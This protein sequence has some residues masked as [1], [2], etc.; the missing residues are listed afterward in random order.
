MGPEP[1]EG[2][3]EYKLMIDG[4][5]AHRMAQLATQMRWRIEEGGGEAVYSIGVED[6]GRCVGLAPDALA[7]S[8]EAVMALAKV[9]DAVVF[10]VIK[11]KGLM[12]DIA[13][14]F[15]RRVISG[16]F[17]DVRVT[18]IGNVDAGKST[19]VGVLTRGGLDNGRG[20]ARSHVFRHAHEIESGRTS[21]ISQQIVGVDATGELVTAS[22]TDAKGHISDLS[23]EQI[24]RKSSKVINFIDLCGHERYFKTTMTG[25]TSYMPDYSLV[26][27]GANAGILRMTKEHVSVAL[28]LKCPL[29]FAVT[30]IDIAPEQILNDSLKGIKKILKSNMAKK[31]GV[32]V[33]SEED[34]LM[35]IKSVRTDKRLVPI[36]QVSAVTGE[37]LQLLRLY[38]SLLPPKA[39]ARAD[40]DMPCELHIDEVFPQVTGIGCVVSGTVRRGRFKDELFKSQQFVL[41]PD[42][43]GKWNRI[44]VK[45]MMKKRS[46][47][48]SIEAGQSGTMAIKGQKKDIK[49]IVPRRGMVL[50]DAKLNPRAC[51]TFEASVLI[52]HHPTTIEVGYSPMVHVLTVRQTV[53]IM[54]IGQPLMRAGDRAN[55]TFKFISHP[56]YLVLN[57]RLIF[58]E[59]KTKGIGIITK[60]FYT[61]G[62][63]DE[64][65][66]PK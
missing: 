22:V 25:M 66:P 40:T 2:N 38:I 26:I 32:L 62:S 41:G 27:V 29:I 50:C 39:Q 46:F 43:S 10:K 45:S 56:E 5:D 23:W 51:F 57:S 17:L 36:F 15:V 52:M 34:V 49:D 14:A 6:S 12:G 58:R 7:A 3:E 13:K 37:N 16:S 21:S 54:E 11:L 19:L 28:A 63:T 30:K 44:T 60:L 1:Q 47:T 53:R 61:D 31:I 4:T 20:A 65:E 9:N 18:V 55:V 42:F 48:T 35:C 24:V 33:K 59:G 8:I 64:I